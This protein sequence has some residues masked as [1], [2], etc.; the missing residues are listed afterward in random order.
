MVVAEHDDAVRGYGS[1]ARRV[2]S[3]SSWWGRD[4]AP[5]W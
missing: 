2:L 5:G 4:V 3:S 1:S